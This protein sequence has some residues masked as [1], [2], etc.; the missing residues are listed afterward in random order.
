MSI[1]RYLNNNEIIVEYFHGKHP[2]YSGEYEEIIE[3][4]YINEFTLYFTK[5]E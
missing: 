5:D 1:R 3:E 2:I 4:G